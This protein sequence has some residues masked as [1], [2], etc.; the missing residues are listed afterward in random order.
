MML[1]GKR[2]VTYKI[3]SLDGG[4][5]RGAITARILDRLLAEVPS[6]LDD[7]QLFAGTS[8]GAILAVALA[9]GN[10]PAD[11]VT[12]Y[13][14]KSKLIFDEG[15]LHEV[16]GLWGLTGARYDTDNRKQAIQS[17]IGAGTLDGLLPRNVFVAT[18]ELD[19]QNPYAQAPGQP[20]RWKAKFFHNFSGPESDGGQLAIDVIMRSSAAPV[21]KAVTSARATTKRPRT[22]KDQSV[23]FW[24][25]S[26]FMVVTAEHRLRCQSIKK[27]Q[28]NHAGALNNP[29]IS[30]WISSAFPLGSGAFLIGLPTTM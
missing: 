2:K 11:L 27:R 7:V 19:S 23:S 10:R 28:S 18:Y 3:L 17:V 1:Q 21:V 26:L 24:P 25:D 6:L 14:T 4:G 16:G 9:Q 29:A 30:R 22:R 13:K 15:L 5:V 8:T 20:R 12:L